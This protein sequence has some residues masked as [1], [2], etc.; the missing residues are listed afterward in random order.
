VAGTPSLPIQQAAA[1]GPAWVSAVGDTTTFSTLDNNKNPTSGLISKTSQDVAG[2]G[3]DVNFL[4]TTEDARYYQSLNADVTAITHAQGGYI[5]GWGGQQVPLMDTFFGGPQLV[6]GFAPNGFGPRDL[7]PGSTMDNVG[8][9]IYWA[10]SEEIQSNIPGV[11]AEFGIKAAF[12]VDAGSLWGYHG[13]TVF[14]GSTQS[15]QI[16]D[17]KTIRSSVGAGLVWASPFGNLSV[18]YA[19]ALTKAPY[20]VTQP[21]NFGAGAF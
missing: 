17:T 12:F 11:P 8:G 7:T 18:N 14:P 21:I 15:V 5:T 2:L 6:R 3:G 4:R 16:A 9:S 10:T 13:P 19:F 1:A 20:D